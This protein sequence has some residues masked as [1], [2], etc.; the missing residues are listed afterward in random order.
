M[1]RVFKESFVPILGLLGFLF[2]LLLYVRY[3]VGLDAD[4]VTVITIQA[5]VVEET[6]SGPLEEESELL[7]T[8]DNQ[9]SEI[10]A[11]IMTRK[12][13]QA[14]SRVK[15]MT[16]VRNDSLAWSLFGILRYKQGKYNEA[17]SFLD[18]AASMTPVWPKLFFY[19]AVVHSRLDKLDAAAD[20]YRSVM[21]FNEN[22]FE[23]HYNLGLLLSR[24]KE[25]PEA[26]A[27]LERASALAGGVRKARAYYQL[28]HAWMRQGAEFYDQA[29]V[30]FNLAIRHLPGFIE[31]RLALAKLH[32]DTEEGRETAERQ[33]LEILELDA[34]NPSALFALA[35]LETASDNINSALVHYQELMQFAPDH[36]A[37]RYNLA[38]LLLKE[39]RWLEARDHFD[40]VIESD[41]QNVFTL[42]N[43][44]R[45]NYR[46]E[47]YPSAIE[48][49]QKALASKNGD[50]PEALLN[51]GLVYVA[52]KDF[53]AAEQSYRQ[54]LLLRDD[55]SSAWYNLGLLFM[56][57]DKNDEALNA[58][59][60]AV[61]LREDYVQA[62]YNLGVLHGRKGQNEK[63]IAA[64]EKA[65]Q[66]RPE[67]TKA[68]LN[69]AVRL[70][71]MGQPLKAIE[72]YRKALESDATYSSA[73]YNM[74]LAHMELKQYEEAEQAVRRMLVLEPDSFN[75]RL[76]LAD[77]LSAVGRSADA[78]EVLEEAVD[79]E[80]N[81][82]LLRLALAK[83][84]RES[85]ELERARREVYKGLALDPEHRELHEE[86]RL[87]EARLNKKSEGANE[88]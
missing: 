57:Q 52:L 73:W 80:S 3:Q 5:S 81:S 11:L 49:Y 55:Y 78:V 7:L 70:A 58:F 82:P 10:L 48:D 32:P 50:Y 47:E 46:L 54:A 15:Q 88:K 65:L 86:L 31:P 20:D 43:R 38:L 45:A 85:N 17:L 64:Y 8:N 59:N 24:K 61:S 21:Q 1:N 67:Y 16:E 72:H 40:R 51:L 84:L 25:Y 74:A 71:R 36:M 87:V 63:S 83:N 56:R 29:S 9:A 12:W 22:H 60:R 68:R 2:L 28:G 79:I 19:R 6:E 41:P 35:Q 34:G 69:L 26:V 44:G 75:A 30:N 27:L 77:S 39:G 33:L 14:E 23:A 53:R 66:L 62:W 76:L 18:R 4:E 42:F 37:G 13:R